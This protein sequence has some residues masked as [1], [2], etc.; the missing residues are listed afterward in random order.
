MFRNTQ[1]IK[2][3][4]KTTHPS[5]KIKRLFDILIISLINWAV[6]FIGLIFFSPVFYKTANPFL[7]TVD[8]LINTHYIGP[9]PDNISF[10]KGQIKG[11]VSALQDPY[12]TFL[13]NQEIQKLEDKLNQKYVGIGIK[14]INENELIKISEVLSNS[15]AEKSGLK[16]NDVILEIDG[17]NVLGQ[18]LE[19]ISKKLAGEKNTKLRLVILRNTEKIVVDITRD[20]IQ[21]P[22]ISF[23]QKDTIGIL[24]INSFGENIDQEMLTVA[25]QIVNSD[26]DKIILD[27]QDNNGGFLEG[28]IDVSSYFVPANSVIAIEKTKTNGRIHLSKVKEISLTNYP[29]VILVN[30]KTASAGEITASAIRENNSESVLVGQTTFGK[31]V[32]QSVFKINDIGY[33][34]L[35]T[36]EWLTSKEKTINQVG[37]EPDIKLSN[38]VDNLTLVLQRFNWET[39]RLS[40]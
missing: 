14:L 15:P 38:E 19:V 2:R 16:A 1:S 32:I 33:L 9:K 4:P 40:D 20:L 13:D 11:Y 3:K 35:T 31:G 10:Q 7:I 17:E 37:V 23:K 18:S 5:L 29:L 21:L 28:A 24:K 36:A 6:F 12:S 26:I 8:S 34:K 39:K 22:Q 25:N 27:L 30:R